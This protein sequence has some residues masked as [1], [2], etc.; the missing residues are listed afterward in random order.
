MKRL[1]LTFIIILFAS[2]LQAQSLS[3]KADSLLLKAL[4]QNEHAVAVL[5]AQ[6]DKIIYQT[7]RGYAENDSKRAADLETIFKI[8]SVSKQ[9]TAAA[10][11]KLVEMNKMALDDPLSKYLPDFP[12]GKEVTIHHL[13]TH[14]SGIKSYTDELNFIDRVTAPVNQKTLIEE[15]K[16]LGYDFAPGEQWKYNNS[17]YFILG[18][19]VEE[20]SG[21]SF[22]S[23]LEKHFFKPAGMTRS[24]VYDNSKT[25][26]NEAIGYSFDSAGISLAL[27]WDM[28]WA[29]GAGNLYSTGGDLHKWNQKLFA[30]RL[31]DK[32]LVKSAHTPVQLNDSS[33][34]PYGYGWSV[35]EYRGLKRIGHSGGL[36]GFLSY[37]VYYPDLEA[38]VAV[39]SN[40]SPP[41]NVVPA[42]FAEQLTNIFFDEH[43]TKNKEIDT[44][45]SL[46]EKYVGKYEYPGGVVMTVTREDNHLYA[47]LTGQPRYEIFP[48]AE[49]QFFW[50]VV[51]AEITFHFNEEG[52]VDYAIHK[53]NGF[54]SKVPRLVEQQE[55]VL[56]E[57]IFDRYSG[58]YN[59][60]GATA[61][62]WEENG[63][64][65][66][67]VTGQPPFQMFP[68]TRN[69]FFLKDVAA[70][71]EFDGDDSEA[72]GFILYQAGQQIKAIRK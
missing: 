33:E 43:L 35:G 63:K 70:E 59:L 50:K 12:Q 3:E 68:K 64:Y 31:L 15:I 56:G 13:L 55:I 40:C 29:G 20:V 1:P 17:A 58:E 6:G 44:D 34:H 18:H 16:T 48:K 7:T 27:D 52:K 49:H 22:N 14:T 72:T 61:K 67:Q 53:Q 36:H 54:E 57:K 8:G 4:P 9:F 38:T 5:V 46:Y 60:N 41:K 26:K 32:K 19:L 25:Y 42:N 37:L 39:L 11:L 47:Q 45:Y 66:V 71:I 28:T 51:E 30:G 62:I 65:F 10:I 21:M 2:I 69:R 23:F 24:G